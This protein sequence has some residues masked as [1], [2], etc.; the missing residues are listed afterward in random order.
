MATNQPLRIVDYGPYLNGASPG[1]AVSAAQMD[2]NLTTI[3]TIGN[4]IR[5]YTVEDNQSYVVFNAAKFGL[6][7]IPS[8]VLANP[9]ANAVSEPR[10]AFSTIIAQNPG[11]KKSLDD[12][13]TVLNDPRT[14][15]ANI[16]FVV[17]GNEEIT[18]VGGWNDAAIIAAIDYVKSRTPAGIKFTTAEP[19]DVAQ[20]QYLFN[21]NG[22]I[23]Q[24]GLGQAVDVIFANSLPYFEGV[25][26]DQAVDQV[27]AEYQQLT[28]TYPGKQVII[29][30]T[31]WPS[32]GS[33]IGSAVPSLANEQTF[34][35]RFI[36]AADQ[37]GIPYG[38]FE[39]A[40][41]AW[42]ARSIPGNSVDANWGL[43]DGNGTPKTSI[44]TLLDKPVPGFAAID[45]TTGQPL[46]ATPQPYT[47]PVASLQEQY[48]NVTS[49]NINISVSTPNWFIHSGSGE[50]AIAVS[51]GTNVLDGGTSSNFLTGGRGTDTFF[52]DDRGP[53]A[54][55]WSTVAGFHAGD[56]AT[57]WGVTPQGFGLAFADG[58]G[59][60]GF[61]GLTLHAT[62]S[63][64]PTA[65][66]TLA[67]FTQTDMT[68][69]RLSVTFGTDTASG[70]AFMFIHGNS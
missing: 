42:K 61:T 51:S 56:A 6:Q 46:P 54:D 64:R 1:T 36:I 15:L 23:T 40:D 43:E 8:V 25:S 20:K 52:V 5:L 65:S 53:T 49:D 3:A 39:I 18:Q 12:F 16:P 30:E 45:T 28:Q 48:I 69:G 14:N 63:A 24:T 11:I 34:W 68:N 67:G 4:A 62:A 26:I 21:N 44:T 9:N 70:S 13:I 50:D 55:I 33:Q 27:I 38:A 60:A 29:S 66:L 58:E 35:Q 2:Q 31:G 17:I 19:A 10:P 22:T 47:G 7:V 59:T 32:A 57:I 41:E 37:A